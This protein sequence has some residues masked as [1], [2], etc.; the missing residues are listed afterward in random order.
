[1]VTF[2]SAKAK[3]LDEPEVVLNLWAYVDEGGY[4]L[5]IAGKAYVLGGDD[6]SKLS[7]LRQLSG[8]DF[9]SAPWQKVPM[10]FSLTNADGEKMRGVAHASMLSDPDI[11]PNLFGSLMDKLASQIPEQIKSVNGEY[12][13]FK[14]EL[15]E[16]PLCVTTTVIEYEDGRLVPMVSG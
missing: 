7:L 4:I 3:E 10:N 1:M 8:T 5:R 6:K 15:P 11:Q 13:L 16:A 9:M 2:K 14:L 12:E